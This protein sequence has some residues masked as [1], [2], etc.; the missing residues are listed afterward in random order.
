MTRRVIIRNHHQNSL[1]SYNKAVSGHERAALRSILSRTRRTFLPR[2]TRCETSPRTMYLRLP[3]FLLFSVEPAA[4][5][6]EAGLASSSFFVIVLA[7]VLALVQSRTSL[8]ALSFF[9]ITMRAEP[10]VP[11]L[12]L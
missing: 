2:K 10:P 3:F 8:S 5:E 12:F 1:W 4:E 6:E 7:L 9:F 11:W